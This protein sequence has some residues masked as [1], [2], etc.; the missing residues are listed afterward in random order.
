MQFNDLTIA[1]GVI[2]SRRRHDTG[3]LASNAVAVCR[4]MLKSLRAGS[5]RERIPAID[6]PLFVSLGAPAALGEG[7]SGKI[8]LPGRFFC[9]AADGA[10]F[11]FQ[12]NLTLGG[13]GPK[14][15]S[16]EDPGDDGFA[17]ST[18]LA[19]SCT[20]DAQVSALQEHAEERASQVL[21]L[22][23][24]LATTIMLVEFRPQVI[25]F[26]ADFSTCFAAAILL[27]GRENG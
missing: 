4:A 7:K 18:L 26:A 2:K 17:A 16:D 12:V 27:E 1:G 23:P 8:Q 22:R 14:Q 21:A 11:P 3:A 6:E 9:V 15:A 10:D 20:A 13:E 25:A 24:V 19:L 5:L